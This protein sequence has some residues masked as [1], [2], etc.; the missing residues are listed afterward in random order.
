MDFQHHNNLSVQALNDQTAMQNTSIFPI[1]I[2][3]I[4]THVNSNF[5]SLIFVFI[6][7]ITPIS[8]YFVR[9]Y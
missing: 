2:N 3:F 6:T 4:L 1:S 9:Q 7:Y 8:S 5:K